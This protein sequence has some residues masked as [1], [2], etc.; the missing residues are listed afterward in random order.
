MSAYKPDVVRGEDGM[1]VVRAP[2]WAWHEAYAASSTA[3]S[4][5]S[6]GN[7]QV[8][9]HYVRFDQRVLAQGA[10]HLLVKRTALWALTP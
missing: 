6:A 10:W 1:S 3:R 4:Q 7:P 8:A 5:R 9:R 2:D